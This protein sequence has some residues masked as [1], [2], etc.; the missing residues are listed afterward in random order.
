[1]LVE[2]ASR[3]S[4][5]VA[6]CIIIVVTRFVTHSHRRESLSRVFSTQTGIASVFYKYGASLVSPALFTSDSGVSGGIHFLCERCL[7][8]Y[9]QLLNLCY[10]LLTVYNSL[11]L[12]FFLLSVRI[13]HRSFTRDAQCSPHASYRSH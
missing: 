7:Q 8:L 12:L 3:V 13:T 5:I 4:L 11:R 9:I 1:M 2:T 6:D 10:S